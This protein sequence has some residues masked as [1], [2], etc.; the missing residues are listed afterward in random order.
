MPDLVVVAMSGGV[1]S[2]VAAAL[3]VQQGYRVIGVTLDMWPRKSAVE[4]VGRHSVC[5]SLESVEDARRVA[6]RLGIPHYTLNF[7]EAFERDVVRN[8]VAEYARGRT[9]NPCIRC[10]RFVK[11]DALLS[12]ARAWGAEHLA[13][14]HYARVDRTP[15]GRF[16]L[17]KAL[18]GAKDQS[19]ALYSLTQEQLAHTLFPLGGMEKAETRRIAADLGLATAEKPESQ[20]L[21]FVPD[22]DYA[23]YLRQQ[24]PALERTGP[25]RNLAGEVVGTHRGIAFYTVGQRKGLGIYGP[26]PLYVVEILSEENTVVVGEQ[27]ELFAQGLVAEDVNWVSVE[28]TAEP[29]RVDA[30][31]RYRAAEVQ[32]WA[33]LLPDGTL[34]IR[35]DEPQR[36]VSP[37]Q[38]VVLYNGDMVVAGGTIRGEIRGTNGRSTPKV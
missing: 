6:D 32:A 29:L 30:K 35:F 9:P 2:S 17:R 1:D 12:K 37:G 27:E 22:G 5:C 7:R 23:G 14:G 28:E 16:T 26:R 8:F 24:Q 36:A 31:I 34:A 21:C 15:T 10:N 25:I 19:Y 18:H 33:R 4:A 20:E 13:T 11:F 3:L 38:A